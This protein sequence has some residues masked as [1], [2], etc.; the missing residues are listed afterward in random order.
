MKFFFY[1][2][3]LSVKHYVNLIIMQNIKIMILMEYLL[4]DIY[5]TVTRF[6]FHVYDMFVANEI[7]IC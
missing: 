7:G 5:S 3:S 2:V 1:Y 6:N 4:S